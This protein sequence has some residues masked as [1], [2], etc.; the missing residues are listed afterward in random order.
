MVVG[1]AGQVEL[2]EVRERLQRLR[3]RL[4]PV[5][6][7]GPATEEAA[8]ESIAQAP[9]RVVW[10]MIRRR[11]DDLVGDFA[12]PQRGARSADVSRADSRAAAA[13]LT[14]EHARQELAAALDE[15]ERR[16]DLPPDQRDLKHRVRR[17]EGARLRAER[18]KT[19]RER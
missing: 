9:R 18:E 14:R 16:A 15:S 10:P 3:E 2:P 5:R 7:Q 4:A 19:E 6:A 13:R 11:H 17:E 1:G 8:R 12:A